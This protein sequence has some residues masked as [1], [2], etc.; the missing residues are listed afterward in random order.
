[1]NSICKKISAL[2]LIIIM[3]T[4]VSY[5]AISYAAIVDGEYLEGI[6][7]LPDDEEHL[8]D[9]QTLPDED[10]EHLE[11]I[12]TL[13]DEDEEHLEGIETLPDEDEEHLE[14]IQTLPDEDE[15]HLEDIQTLP[16]ENEELEQTETLPDKSDYDL[17]ITNRNNT[18]Q[19]HTASSVAKNINKG[20]SSDYDV[21]LTQDQYGQYYYCMEKG[22]ALMLYANGGATLREF[23]YKATSYTNI[24]LEQ[25]LVLAYLN[26]NE[27]TEIDGVSLNTNNNREKIIQYYIWKTGINQGNTNITVPSVYSNIISKLQKNI[28]NEIKIGNDIINIKDKTITISGT[29]YEIESFEAYKYTSKLIYRRDNGKGYIENN[30]SGCGQEVFGFS[31]NLIS[32]D[33]PDTPKI[34]LHKVDEEKVGLNGAVFTLYDRETGKEIKSYQTLEDGYTDSIPVKYGKEYIIKETVAPYGYKLSTEYVILSIFGEE[35]AAQYTVYDKNGNVLQDGHWTEDEISLDYLI[36]LTLED[37]KEETP[38]PTPPT[39]DTPDIPDTPDTT[40]NIEEAYPLLMY[41]KGTVFLDGI[42]GKESI[43][44][45]YYNKENSTDKGL[46]GIKVEIYDAATNNLAAFATREA[47]TSRTENNRTYIVEN[48]DF[49]A[50]SKY[51]K[52]TTYTDENGFYEFYGLNPSHTYYIVFTY[53]GMRY[54]EVKTTAETGINVSG[55]DI[56]SENASKATE[57]NRKEKITDVFS[58]IGTYPY[59]Y[60]SKSKGGYNI[61]YNQDDVEEAMKNGLSKCGNNYETLYNNLS[62]YMDESMAYFIKDCQVNA[63]IDG[64]G[65]ILKDAEQ[66]VKEYNGSIKLNTASMI[67][68]V[69]EKHE[70]PNIDQVQF[71]KDYGYTVYRFYADPITDTVDG[72]TVVIG[73]SEPYWHNAGTGSVGTLNYDERVDGEWIS[74][75]SKFIQKDQELTNALNQLIAQSNDSV[76]YEANITETWLELK[77]GYTASTI[78]D[79]QWAIFDLKNQQYL[80]GWYNKCKSVSYKDVYKLLTDNLKTLNE[81][82]NTNL[83]CANLG[84]Q[85]RSTFDMALYDDVMKADVTVNGV[86]GTYKYD[87]RAANGKAFSFGVNESD[88]RSYYTN[89]TNGNVE[90]LRNLKYNTIINSTTEYFNYIRTTDIH[91]SSD[92]PKTDNGVAQAGGY[93]DNNNSIYLTYKIR[94]INQSSIKGSITEVVDY[95]NSDFEVV[96]VYNKDNNE[97]SFSN[98]SIYANRG[99]KNDN[100]DGYNKIYIKLDNKELANNEDIELYLV[101]KM[102][103]IPNTLTEEVLNRE[104]GYKTLNLAEING[105]KTT[106]GYIDID[107]MPGNVV[108]T[109]RFA[110]GKYEDDES[111]SPTLIFKNPNKEGRTIAGIIFEDAVTGEIVNKDTTRQSLANHQFDEND[112]LIEGATVQ[113]IQILADGTE[114]ISSQTQTVNGAYKFTNIRPGNYVIRF[115]YGNTDKTALTNKNIVDDEGNALSMPNG[116]SYNGESFENTEKLSNTSFGADGYWYTDSDIETNIRYSDAVDNKIRREEVT[117]NFK[118]IINEK[119]EILSSYKDSKVN[120]SLVTKLKEQ[121]YMYATTDVMK[122]EMEYV[123]TKN[124]NT[125]GNTT[126]ANEDGKYNYVYDITNVDFGI[127]ERSRAKLDLIKNVSYISLI[128]SSENEIT[129]GTYEQWKNGNIKYI[130]WIMG[131]DGFVD[132]EIDKELLSGATIK[133]TYDI[134]V[135]DN[136]E[137]GNDISDIVVVDYVTNNINYSADYIN[138]DGNTNSFY[139]WETTTTDDLINKDKYVNS[140]SALNTEDD[141]N[142]IDISTYQ[143]IVKATFKPGETK[144]LTLEKNL[145]PEENSN[146]NYENR[147]EIVSST[148]TKGRGDYSSIYGNLDP[149][150]YTSRQGNLYWDFIKGVTSSSDNDTDSITENTGVNP[151]RIAEPD[152]ASAE[153]TIVSPPQGATGIV[154][155]G[156]YFIFGLTVLVSFVI[157]LILIKK[158]KELE[159]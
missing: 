125:N 148:N 56:K 13:P 144:K 54:V 95:Y 109:N 59:N 127:V 126:T 55:Y 150:T 3:L 79:V 44:D 11:G 152:S 89:L 2:L 94:I 131:E 99:T 47:L 111:K 103:D 119:A 107:S 154:I 50:L 53:N 15:E 155:S 157:G 7:T 145:S 115:A 113:L 98:S 27:V 158:Y 57:T 24:T 6:E 85:Y 76:R 23:Y 63:R 70:Y 123:G 105:Y 106:N 134:T 49:D 34:Q 48:V 42:E 62:A 41:I 61:A 117:N 68:P 146:F 88:L 18:Q 139:G 83:P 124:E 78:Q 37:E 114:K 143:T 72:Q 38:P 20:D 142:K 84:V 75:A 17:M 116:K 31:S 28:N 66:K 14:D 147:A 58:E 67:Y 81:D 108:E 9:I 93:D 51:G 120:R 102:K 135:K 121:A 101:L 156:E 35:D 73:Y 25:K 132:M 122:L 151:I 118:T 8:E 137:A 5:N 45:G 16:D 22:G 110:E 43:A 129:G 86:L 130:K 26:S 153:E 77:E 97:Y 141:I 29:D 136:S 69:V 74:V 87:K 32:K 19:A 71:T 52:A 1:M 133:I 100:V 91:Y 82:I 138:N 104:E 60:Y 64:L 4:S 149:M 21:L 10:E 80:N 46:A 90:A 65:N 39:P 12:E 159:A 40:P 96:K 33:Q 92:V 128:D 36:I 140:K 112:T 30:Y